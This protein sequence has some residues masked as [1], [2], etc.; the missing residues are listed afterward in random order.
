MGSLLVGLPLPCSGSPG[1]GY[2]GPGRVR[3]TFVPAPLALGVPA[4]GATWATPWRVPWVGGPQSTRGRAGGPGGTGHA[5]TVRV[6]HPGQVPKP[7]QGP[8]TPLGEG[9]EVAA[10]SP[11]W[12]WGRGAWGGGGPAGTGLGCRD[13][14]AWQGDGDEASSALEVA[15]E[16]PEPV[17]CLSPATPQGSDTPQDP[18]GGAF[19]GLAQGYISGPP[20]PKWGPPISAAGCRGWGT[21]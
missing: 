9:R 5:V 14:V 11:G 10:G 18:Q 1:W 13:R 3:V 8:Q 17:P 4:H 15:A 7:L 6:T 16:T 19:R 12:V 2:R 20:N 21:P